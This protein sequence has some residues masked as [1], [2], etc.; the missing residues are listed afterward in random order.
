[1][2]Q[3]YQFL[4][5]LADPFT[6]L[7]LLLGVCVFWPQRRGTSWRLG[8]KF[9]YLLTY[10][11][12]T[13]LAAYSST[14]WLERIAPPTLV[15]PERLDAIVVL[16]GGL[17]VPRGGGEDIYLD[18]ASYH[19]CER[20]AELYLAGEPCPILSTGGPVVGQEQTRVPASHVMSQTLEQ[21]GVA[22]TDLLVEAQA[23]TT[24]ENARLSA[25]IIQ[26]RGWQRVALVTSATHLFRAQRLFRNHGIETIPVGCLYRTEE[27][28]W[29]A[30]A[31]LPRPGAV[32]RQQEACH[33]FLGCAYLMLRGK[34]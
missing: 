17:H 9:C 23:R 26:E 20:A 18:E 19:R 1:M 4:S 33:E 12:C 14:W 16:G 2:S 32:A 28:E 8:L 30:F 10:L 27:F 7:M 29:N 13:P 5:Q 34:W 21:L 3:A 15:R 6:L 22:R 24:E 31:F 11:Y 25:A